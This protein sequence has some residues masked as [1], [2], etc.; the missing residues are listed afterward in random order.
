MPN[1]RNIKYLE[2]IKEKIEV[3]QGFYFTNFSGLNVKSITDLRKKLKDAEIDYLVVKNR[4]LALALKDSGI[5]LESLGTLLRGQVG[6]AIGIEDGYRPANVLS[7]I[8]A[9][10]PPF[11]IKGALIDGEVFVDDRLKTLCSLPGRHES[12][13]QLAIILLNPIIR[14]PTILNQLLSQLVI[15]LEEIKKRRSDDTQEK[16]VS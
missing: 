2:I 9:D 6:L 11:K 12:E 16:V 14:F 15:A 7:K 5:N 10:F 4:L 3:G 1:E 13:G 8:E